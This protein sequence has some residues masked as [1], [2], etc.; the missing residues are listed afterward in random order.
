MIAVCSVKSASLGSVEGSKPLLQHNKN[1][2]S[3]SKKS[4]MLELQRTVQISVCCNQDSAAVLHTCML[5]HA[6]TKRF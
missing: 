2:Y 3:T 1:M 4:D 5:R 6:H